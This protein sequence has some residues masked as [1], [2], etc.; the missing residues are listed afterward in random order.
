MLCHVLPSQPSRG[1]GQLPCCAFWLSSGKT[2]AGDLG[3][4]QGAGSDFS[5]G[6]VVGSCEVS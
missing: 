4:L 6:S 1:G 3:L 2:N 5:F